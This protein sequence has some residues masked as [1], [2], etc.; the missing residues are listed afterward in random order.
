MK[1]RKLLGLCVLVAL[2]CAS[3]PSSKLRSLGAPSGSGPVSFEVDNR[4]QTIVNNLYLAESA[5][6]KA[7]GRK[8][9]EAGSP[10]QVELWGND[11]LRSGLEIRG[12]VPVPISA[13]GRYDVRVVARDGER[14]QRV[15]GLRLEAGGRYVL[16][17][18]EG[19]WRPIQ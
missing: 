18:H 8:A 7:A 6:V 19:G 2:G 10:E 9:F 16:E 14:E 15:T 1:R 4:T 12:K 13:P 11:L 17:L 5:R 3:G